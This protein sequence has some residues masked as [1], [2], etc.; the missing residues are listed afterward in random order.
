MSHRL[1]INCR[2]NSDDGFERVKREKMER[3]RERKETKLRIRRARD[4]SASS[5]PRHGMTAWK[6]W[7]LGREVTIYQRVQRMNSQ[8]PLNERA[9]TALVVDATAK[10]SELLLLVNSAMIKQI[11]NV[12]SLIKTGRL[13]DVFDYPRI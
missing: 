3:E 6:E 5:Q 9:A 11:D 4:G 2:N 13:S 1:H 12:R 10:S 8:S 7:Q